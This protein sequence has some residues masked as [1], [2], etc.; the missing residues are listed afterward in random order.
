MAQLRLAEQIIAEKDHSIRAI[1]YR[2]DMAILEKE[3]LEEELV[4]LK[5]TKSADTSLS[6]TTL[7]VSM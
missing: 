5:S 7:R 2:A 1:E 4:T 6:E 3:A